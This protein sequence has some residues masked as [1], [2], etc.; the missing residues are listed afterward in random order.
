[1]LRAEAM[2]P[3]HVVVPWTQLS[4]GALGGVITEFVT[5]EGTEYGAH[6]VPLEAKVAQ[7]RAQLQSGHAVILFHVESESVNI[8]LAKDVPASPPS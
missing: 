7:V 2:E 8:V 4:E 1:M 6:D 5:R 3:R